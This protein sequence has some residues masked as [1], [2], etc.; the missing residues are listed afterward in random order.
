MNTTKKILIIP[1]M[2]V[3]LAMLVS[4]ASVT[5]SL[6]YDSTTSNTLQI[7]EGDS[8]GVIISADSIFESSMEITLDIIDPLGN[9]VNN[10]LDTFT[11]S[12]S[13]S[14]YLI[15]G[16]SAFLTPGNYTIVATVRAASGQTATD[17][18]FL[19][20]LP[21]PNVNN[22]PVITSVPTTQINENTNYVYQVTATDADGNTLT[23]TLTQAPSWLSI[24]SVT[25]LVSGTA[26]NVVSD[27][28]Y[29]ITVSVSDGANFDRQTFDL[30]VR[31]TN[32]DTTPPVITVL[33]PVNNQ[34]YTT[35]NVLFSIT[36]NE[37]SG[38]ARFT[39]TTNGNPIN[40]SMTQTSATSF[41]TNMS[42]PDG[43][44][45]VVVYA[46]DLAGNIGQSQSI[47]FT[48]NI[49]PTNNAPVITSTPITQVGEGASYSYQIVATDADGNT[50]SYSF[51]GPS[52]LSINSQTGLLSGTAQFVN[53][54]LVFL[55]L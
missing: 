16:Q 31:D 14:N 11:T 3:F 12:D 42:L 20:V 36:T 17:I 21:I 13:Y 43:T 26:P 33:S 44:Y 53:A 8:F 5:T 1:L 15:F 49:P 51:S 30:T 38:S 6:F 29:T 10:V 19:E 39:I 24:N 28:I 35:S 18:L 41:Q 46:T 48:V 23:Y 2:L 27:Y 47:T 50:L 9:R 4:A 7:N 52:W 22:P 32:L 25:G 54:L 55:F 40:F 34:V 45:S 37:N